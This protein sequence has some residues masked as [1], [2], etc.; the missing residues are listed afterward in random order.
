VQLRRPGRGPALDEPAAT[1]AA[2]RSCRRG[3]P[4]PLLRVRD[5]DARQYPDGRFLFIPVESPADVADILTI[6]ATKLPPTIRA[7]VAA[8]R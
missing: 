6:L 3:A 1:G 8:A 5:A 2:A 4:A 7:K